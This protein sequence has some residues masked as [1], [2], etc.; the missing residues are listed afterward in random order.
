[1]RDVIVIGG[2]PAGSTAAALLA[3]KGFSVL[4]LE[5][6]KFPR[7]QIG[8]SLLPYNM[9]LFD[10]LGIRDQLESGEFLPKFG[11]T[12]IT[13]DGE[14][15]YDFSF[16]RTLPERYSRSYQVKR[17]DFDD[18]L[19]RNAARHGAEVRE[20]V[21]VRNVDLASP[22]RAVVETVSVD[23]TTERHEARF[24]VDASGHG[25]VVG[26]KLG[27]RIDSPALKKVSFFA[28]YTNVAPAGE[29]EVE[30]NTV[31]V[32]LRNGWFWMIPLS[33]GE[34][35]VGLVLDRDEVRE[36]GLSPEELLAKTIAAA[37]YVAKRMTNA[38][39]V[40]QVRARKDFSYRMRRLYGENFV[41]AGDAA[42]FID[43]IFSTGVFMA[44][45]SAAIV[46][47]AVAEKLRDG[48]DRL[49]KNYERRFS[50]A[51]EKYLRFVSSFYTR[52]F[53][54]VFLQPS[55][56]FGLFP[57]IIDILAG[58]VFEKRRDRFKLALFFSIVRLQR[59]RRVIARPISWDKLP[60]TARA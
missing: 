50:A 52:E 32:V 25:T 21:T 24:V 38:E 26:A 34:M 10:Q 31:I 16:R 11:A 33:H 18:I 23:G 42:G 59:M 5:R 6:E 55:A 58:N 1:M 45:K 27:E 28:H 39:R 17:E 51:F 46:S 53:L 7:F 13:G 3:Q 57:V 43:P 37:P 44:M 4:V 22:E 60:A 40:S 48:K 41:L 47:D 54:E 14:L 30:G 2:G 15:G 8:E 9:D 36:C 20:Q 19:L 56:R 29:G 49:L 12:F 35:S